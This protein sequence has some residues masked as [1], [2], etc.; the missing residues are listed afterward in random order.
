M[1]LG[2]MAVVMPYGPAGLGGS[3]AA[4][5]LAADGTA[6]QSAQ[7]LMTMRRVS[8]MT[9]KRSGEQGLVAVASVRRPSGMHPV[10]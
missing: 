1:V 5:A 9:S 6:M 10:V 4:D 3:V 8:M 7:A 2:S